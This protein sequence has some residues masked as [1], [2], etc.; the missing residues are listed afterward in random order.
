MVIHNDESIVSVRILNDDRWEIKKVKNEI[1][2]I[3]ECGIEEND[4]GAINECRSGIA[5]GKFS[6]TS[7]IKSV[8]PDCTA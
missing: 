7:S 1:I 3:I 4:T 2:I 5:K 8:S 6:S